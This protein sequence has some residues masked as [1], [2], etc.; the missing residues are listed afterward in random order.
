MTNTSEIPKHTGEALWI[1]K[2]YTVKFKTILAL[3]GTLLGGLGLFCVR[4]HGPCLNTAFT[5][6]EHSGKLL[7]SLYVDL[8][9][10]IF[11]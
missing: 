7:L 10:L 6:W 8:Q 1:Y 3:Q 9:E 11:T 5:I 2:I 4:V